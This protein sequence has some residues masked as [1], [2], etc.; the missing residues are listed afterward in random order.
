MFEFILFSLLVTVVPVLLVFALKDRIDLMDGISE[1]A[2][3]MLKVLPAVLVINIVIGVYVVRAIR[4]P[5][6]YVVYGPAE[7]RREREVEVEGRKR[8][9]QEKERGMKKEN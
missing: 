3:T 6:N 7:R 8:E 2:K 9:E 4:D 1:T 5:E